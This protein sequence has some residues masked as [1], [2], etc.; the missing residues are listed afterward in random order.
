MLEQFT[1]VIRALQTP[2]MILFVKIVGNVKLKM[3]TILPRRL[4]LDAWLGP[5]VPL[6]IDT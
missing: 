5:D 3:L 6:Q 4:I 1:S 2:M